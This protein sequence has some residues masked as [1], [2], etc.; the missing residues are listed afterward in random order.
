MQ[1]IL[2][3]YYEPIPSGQTTHVLSLV[4]GLNQTRYQLTVALPEI[5]QDTFAPY[6]S[7]GVRVVPLRM[8]K[9]LWNRQA[10]WD[11]IRLIRQ[12]RFDV[13]HVHSQEAGVTARLIAWLAGAPRIFYTPQTIN[14]YR[15][16]AQGLYILMELL[17]S[18]WTE[19]I[20]SVNEIDRRQLAAWGIHP[21]KIS[22]IP[23]G[24]DLSLFDQPV[25]VAGIKQELGL[26]ENHPVV[27]QVG[28][29]SPQ[30]NPPGLCRWG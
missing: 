6:Q 15:K 28:R 19:R 4:H 11:L 20:I 9:I 12:E 7:R 26:I 8:R 3:V 30:K 22:T 24:I 5:L 10:V 16:Q 17:W 21:D 23:N 14:I 25:D 27:M 18:R 2:L 29:L 13:V 1:K